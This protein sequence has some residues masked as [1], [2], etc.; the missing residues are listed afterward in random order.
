VTVVVVAVIGAAIA[1]RA[2]IVVRAATRVGTT[3][4]PTLV[5]PTS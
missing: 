3:T 4:A 1:A 2:V 5:C